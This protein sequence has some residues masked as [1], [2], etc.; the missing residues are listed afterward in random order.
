MD[1]TPGKNPRKEPTKKQLAFPLAALPRAGF[2]LVSDGLTLVL[3]VFSD[4][5]LIGVGLREFG[6]GIFTGTAL[7]LPRPPLGVWDRLEPA[8][9]ASLAGVPCSLSLTTAS[10][11]WVIWECRSLWLTSLERFCAE[12]GRHC[13]G[14]C[15]TLGV[16]L[17]AGSVMSRQHVRI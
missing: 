11:F 4:R 10:S 13:W 8:V 5:A 2:S 17:S 1:E 3:A 9:R 15:S 6:L 12:G 7:A 16:G 14:C